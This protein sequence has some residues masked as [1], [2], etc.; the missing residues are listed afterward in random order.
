MD[1]LDSCASWSG[2]LAAATALNGIPGAPEYKL[3]KEQLLFEMALSMIGKSL[4]GFKDISLTVAR[5]GSFPN[6]DESSRVTAA[7]S[8]A[9]SFGILAVIEPW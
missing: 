5:L 6:D 2:I 1:K 8:Q 4:P 9:D 3:F 7:M